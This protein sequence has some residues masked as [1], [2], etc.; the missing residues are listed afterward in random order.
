M[1]NIY[2]IKSKLGTLIAKSKKTLI[3]TAERVD[4]EKMVYVVIDGI[5]AVRCPLSIYRDA[6]QLHTRTDAPEVGTEKDASGSF[7]EG[8]GLASYVDSFMDGAKKTAYDTGFTATGSDVKGTIRIFAS[9]AGAPVLVYSMYVDAFDTSE[10]VFSCSDSHSP[11]IIHLP[12]EIDVLI[13][14]VRVDD[15]RADAF[16]AIADNTV[17]QNSGGAGR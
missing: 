14:P 16:I 12:F 6:L 9:E 3:C 10:T 17:Q 13:M 4:G 8:S 11:V 5:V 7:C 15:G 2:G 1:K